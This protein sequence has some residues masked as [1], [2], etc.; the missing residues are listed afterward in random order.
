MWFNGY[1]TLSAAIILVFICHRRPH[2]R[3]P[4]FLSSAAFLV[5]HRRCP[6]LPPPSSSVSMSKICA[7]TFYQLLPQIASAK[8]IC[9]LPV[10]TSTHPHCN[11]LTITIALHHVLQ[12]LVE[13]CGF[14]QY[15]A[16][17]RHSGLLYQQL[18][19][20]V[21]V[22]SSLGQLFMVNFL[23]QID[24][25]NFVL[26]DKLTSLIVTSWLEWHEGGNGVTDMSIIFHL[27][28]ID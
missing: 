22:N 14:L 26:C 12:Y 27:L 10:A 9:N 13:S 16:A 19:C 3:L 25:V 21:V 11:S 6:H 2:R 17:F 20:W 15:C 8:F 5:I 28:D 1:F 23:W 7:S 24:L 18:F 4:S